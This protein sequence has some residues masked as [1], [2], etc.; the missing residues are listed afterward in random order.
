M[1]ALRRVGVPFGWKIVTAP[2]VGRN[3]ADMAASAAAQLL[4]R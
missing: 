2:G 3:D 1:Q 4:S